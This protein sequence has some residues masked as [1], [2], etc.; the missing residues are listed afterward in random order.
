M[1]ILA[2]QDHWLLVGVPL[3]YL[4]PVLDAGH[5]V[6]YF[7]GEVIF[8]EGDPADGLYLITAGA[9]RVTATGDSGET[10]LA[11]VKA[12]E[13]LGEMGVLDG[14]PRSGTAGAL[15]L[16][17]GYFLPT[18]PFLDLL[19]RSTAVCMRLLA[20]LTTRLRIA[21]GRLGELPAIAAV[22]PEEAAAL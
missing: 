11:V 20:I 9:V 16:C 13:V 6:A 10:F 15:T 21:N 8:H 3:E 14:E 7:P 18:E 5:E 19:E 4:Q 17:R 2:P 12:N 1:N 22:R